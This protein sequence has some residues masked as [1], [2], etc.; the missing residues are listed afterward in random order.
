MASAGFMPDC[1]IIGVSLAPLDA[2]GFHALARGAL[3]EFF[4]RPVT[5]AD[6]PAWRLPFERAWRSPNQLGG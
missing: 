2:D 1:R 5:D 3:D 4:N 6:W